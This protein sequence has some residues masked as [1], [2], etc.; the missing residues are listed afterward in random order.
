L[1]VERELVGNQSRASIRAAEV[2]GWVGL[3]I[4]WC[5]IGLRLW[6]FRTLGRYCRESGM[7]GEARNG[8]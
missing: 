3:G 5:G 4:M 2:A 1:S 6:S 8:E 7:T